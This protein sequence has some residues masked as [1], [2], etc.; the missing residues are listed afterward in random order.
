VGMPLMGEGYEK[1]VDVECLLV[2]EGFLYCAV[3][4]ALLI[5][6]RI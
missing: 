6:S 4:G 3:F 1:E 5:T 2:W